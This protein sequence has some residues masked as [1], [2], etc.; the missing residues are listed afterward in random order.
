MQESVRSIAAISE[1]ILEL[2]DGLGIGDLTRQAFSILGENEIIRVADQHTCQECTQ[3]YKRRADI[4][5]EDDPAALVGMDENCNV[6][7]LGGENADIATEA[8][9]QARK[10][11]QHAASAVTD[12]EMDVDDLNDSYTTMAVVDGI[13]ISLPVCTLKFQLITIANIVLALCL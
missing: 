6:P 5:T 7:A 2:Q 10:N 4:I 13:V 1:I 3:P 12:E 8:A 9:E 11:G